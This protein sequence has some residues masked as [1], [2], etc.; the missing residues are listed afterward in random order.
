MTTEGKIALGCIGAFL[1]IVGASIGVSQYNVNKERA[2]K[3]KEVEN[4]RLYFEK[5][6]PEQVER[7]EKEKLEVKKA[8]IELDKALADK[9]RSEDET[10]RFVADF[11]DS[12]T[13]QIRKEV[14]TSIGSDMRNTFDRWS[15]RFEDRLDAKVDR[16][17]ERVDKLSDRY[18]GVKEASTA[19]AP[20]PSIQVVNAPS[21]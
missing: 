20:L 21:N 9:K 3:E 5:L 12:I 4:K 19:S 17:V 10:K 6:T 13:E 1:A 2:L 8:Q 11:K 16:V 15:S 14:Y 18:G 7:L